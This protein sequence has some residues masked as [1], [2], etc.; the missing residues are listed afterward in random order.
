MDSVIESLK[1]VCE[2]CGLFVLEKETKI[3]AIENCL[4]CNSI[5]LRL[6]TFSHI[7]SYAIFNDNICLCLIC[8]KSLLFGNRPKFGILHGLPC[9]DCQSYLFAPA[10]PSIAKKLLLLTRIW[11]CLSLNLGFLKLLI[12]Q[13]ILV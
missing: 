6:L 2:C 8:D 3:Y 1:C 9:V 10:D 5:T 13:H 12:R 11:S 4:I 7:D